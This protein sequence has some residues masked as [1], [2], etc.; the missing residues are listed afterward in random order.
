VYAS[1]GC[2]LRVD[3]ST[4]FLYPSDGAIVKRSAHQPFHLIQVLILWSA[5][6]LAARDEGYF[7]C[8]VMA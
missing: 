8:C 5:G 4:H 2:K 1:E 6:R 3:A 7:M